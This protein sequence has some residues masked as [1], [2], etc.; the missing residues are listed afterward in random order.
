MVSSALIQRFDVFLVKLDPTQGSEIQK[1]RPCVIISPN[2][3][4]AY[5]STLIIAPMTTK[6]R[7]YPTRISLNFDAKEGY[8][9]LDQIRTVDRERLIKKL[10]YVEKSIQTQIL[11]VLRE[12]FAE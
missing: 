3:M 8:I 12:M 11:S 2:E 4:N 9:I 10:G 6:S 7:S 1:T 5:I